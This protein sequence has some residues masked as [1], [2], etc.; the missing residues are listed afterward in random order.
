[1][2]LED[3]PRPKNDNRRGIHWSASV[4]HPTGSALDFWI[5]ELQSLNIKWVKLLDDGGG[6]SLEL[7]Q[8]LL[9]ADIMPVVRLYRLEPNPGHIGGRE[10]DTLRR[11]AAAGVRYFE[12]NNEPD[13]PAE[14][15]GGR[16]PR[17]WL[18]IVI[19]NFIYDAD[20]VLAA[21][22]LPAL[23]AMGVG[24]HNNP[25]EEVVRKGRA[26]LF[27]NGAW[28]A[29]HNYT[30]NHPLDYPYDSVNQ[31]GT[32]VSQEE[33]ERLGPWA[34]EGIP[35]A[36][37]NEWRAA[38]KNPGATL[39]DD[40]VGFLAF[41]L[42]DQMAVKAFGH[43]VPI[44]STEGGPV[45]GWRD[46][47]RYPRT[48]PQLLAD[49]A[50]AINDF[51]QGRREFH[52]IRC[53]DSYFTMCHW[54][55]A[56][57]RLGFM[58]PGWESQSWYTDW[59]NGEFSLKGEMPVVAAVKAMPSVAVDDT[60]RATVMGRVLRADTD[61]PLSGLAVRLL[62][63]TRE[64]ATATTGDDGSF[65]M[66]RLPRGVYDLVIAPWG[67][68]RQGLEVAPGVLQPLIIRLAG[69][70]GSVLGGQ[71]VG[72]S[73]APVPGLRA[74]LR[75]DGKTVAET[76]T[77]ADGGFRFEGLPLGSYRL[78][79]PG[80][81]VAGIALDGFVSKNLKLSTQSGSAYRYAVAERRLLPAD[82]NGGRS[83]FFGTVS[84]AQGNPLNGVRVRMSWEGAAPGTV[85][86][87]QTT[88][89]DPYRP[90]GRYEFVHTAGMFALEV[91]QGDWPSDVVA[92]LD[93]T[94]VGGAVSYEVDFQLQ[95]AGAMAQVD[96]VIVGASGGRLRLQGAGGTRETTPEGDGRFAFQGL[97]P[98]AYR[99]EFENY[100][101]LAPDIDLAAGARFTV[102]APFLSKI[103]GKA[104]G[105]TEG[106]I[107]VLYAPPALGWTRQAPLEPDGSFTF[108]GLPA[109]H[110]R[111]QI[112]D[113]LLPDI[114][115]TGESRLQ[116]ADIDL[117]QGKRSAL[118]GRVVDTSGNP[119]SDIAMSLRNDG[120][121]VALA[122]SAAD[123]GYS[124]VSLPAGMYALEVA[125]MGQ[126]AP[127][128]VLDGQSEA[129]NDITWTGV[130]PR[131]LVQGRVLTSSGAAQ[132]DATVRLVR[133][134]VEIA[135][136]H[137]DRDG[138]FRFPGL[139][140]GNY[141]LALEEADMVVPG[142]D[143]DE[144]VA[145][146]RDVKLPPGPAKEIAHYFLFER[147]G[148]DG[149]AGLR[150]ALTL[151]GRYM[152]RLGATGGFSVGEAGHAGLV[153]IVGD[154][155]ASVEQSLQAAGCQ[156]NRLPGDGYVMAAVLEQLV[157]KL[158][159]G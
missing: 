92:G 151:A 120:L 150:L 97:P 99:L 75:R 80:I 107:A 7:C 130:G 39:E 32:P 34:W 43:P 57:Y 46:D 96:G 9:A 40:A 56:N 124:F 153:T 152:A 2:R 101:A 156:V 67:V 114:A 86:P 31:E 24:S 41:H 93:T 65:R 70:Q 111:L 48:G 33:Y 6:S 45:M 16:K 113:V 142:V 66:D 58:A 87:V 104:I 154:L 4:Y 25:M 148:D 83:I 138:K 85:F 68:V 146:T 118:R 121:V 17:N 81:T 14:W 88:G 139:S 94:K 79:V 44:I 1:M 20:R 59:W 158:G 78:E 19:D 116:M 73:G 90:T 144:D 155:P 63:G 132:P 105:V 23:P 36:T 69:G 10:E 135:R 35:R 62:A 12:T 53:P 117:A 157:V 143:L 76:V 128:L 136:T 11:M 71:L 55:L 115:L 26:D 159:E 28:I 100:G 27:D 51:M 47:R 82:E 61:G 38:D 91:V 141:A 126:V 5:R 119:Q 112:D 49:A 15:Q 42:V 131:S 22:G 147:P 109:G 89:H 125:G 8:R 103:T 18:D 145:V 123:G 122:R 133:D 137:T 54:L 3:F 127:G 98:G 30:L 77:G 129:T 110:Y 29:I 64:V 134:G 108:G 84:D 21:G 60:N 52:G 50:V 72:A 13:L 149:D 106:R 95:T 102:I 74:V 140:G 37:I